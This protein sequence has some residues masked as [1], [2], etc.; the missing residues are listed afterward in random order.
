MNQQPGNNPQGNP[1]NSNQY[2]QSPQ[3]QQPQPQQAPQPQQQT[4]QPR[5]PMPPPRPLMPPQGWQPQPQPIYY[6][7]PYA[8]IPKQK[9]IAPG[10]KPADGVFAFLALLA[11]FMVIRYLFAPYTLGAGAFVFNVLLTLFACFY[12]K[13]NNTKL[14]FK[15]CLGFGVFV[16][17]S[18]YY[19]FITNMLLSNLLI[20]LQLIIFA[21]SC[22]IAAGT[23]LKDEMGN[24]FFADLVNEWIFIPFN[25]LGMIFISIGRLIKKSKFFKSFMFVLAGLGITL[26]LLILVIWLLSEAD[27]AFKLFINRIIEDFIENI[28]IYI[29][30]IILGIPFAVYLFGFLFG[31][32]K[33]RY[34]KNMSVESVSQNAGYFRVMPSIMACGALS[35]FILFYTLF[36][37]SQI[38]YY[39]SAFSMQIPE[40]F[41]YS[42]YARK[43]FFELCIVAAINFILIITIQNILKSKKS[44]LPLK[45][46]NV[47]ISLYTLA[48]I[49]IAVSKM[50]LYI[51]HGGLTKLRLY[52]SWFMLLLALIFIFIIIW[53]FVPKF[54]AIKI[55]FF[56]TIAMS[57][58]ICFANTDT[59]I[60]RHNV[61]RVLAGKNVGDTVQHLITLGDAAIPE[62]DRLYES[63]NED[64]HLRSMIYFELNNYYSMRGD[65]YENWEAKTR[66]SMKADEILEKYKEY[67]S[68]Y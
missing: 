24:F 46:I 8:P 53:Q 60:A 21:Y 65:R 39:T 17:S 23:R 28:G 22:S 66:M 27:S 30:Q 20:F 16:L 44:S 25:N 57:F 10:F 12:F 43:G 48:F 4:Q 62:L 61:D 15:A 45:I 32:V 59:L 47:W 40:G 3:Q 26:P 6:N 50:I 67:K 55:S 37:F 2:S 5:Q 64:S 38:E 29:L 31:T 54:D 11:G 7:S 9:R 14:P 35:G 1:Q 18:V 56:A 33:K 58:I 36:F 41:S 52:T 19:I 68:N 63:V 13:F 51:D 42:N 34:T 49:A